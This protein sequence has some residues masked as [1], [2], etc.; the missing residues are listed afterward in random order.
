MVYTGRIVEHAI[1]SCSVIVT[2][3]RLWLRNKIMTFSSVLIPM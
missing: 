2:I 1:R 3:L